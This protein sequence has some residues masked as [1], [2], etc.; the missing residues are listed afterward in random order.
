MSMTRLI[1]QEELQRKLE[2]LQ[3]KLEDLQGEQQTLKKTLRTI[4]KAFI[5]FGEG[6]KQRLNSHRKEIEKWLLQV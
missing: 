3:E 6:D 4:A 2:C 5:A 1:S